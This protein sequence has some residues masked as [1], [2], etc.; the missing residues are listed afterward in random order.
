MRE[1]H[2]R[3]C[4]GPRHPRSAGNAHCTAVSGVSR[5]LFPSPH[6]FSPQMQVTAVLYLNSASEFEGGLFHFEDR[7]VEPATEHTV[8]PAAG[9][10]NLFTSGPENRHRVDTVTAGER[11]M[12]VSYFAQVD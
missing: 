2:L 1:L 8:T 7:D 9:L 12:L 6:L 11:W 10:L 3:L 4:V 5:S